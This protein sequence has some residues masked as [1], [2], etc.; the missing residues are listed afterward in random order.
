MVCDIEI[1]KNK[2]IISDCKIVI[3]G[4]GEVG[5]KT[6]NV[7]RMCGINVYAFCKT[8]P[9]RG[10]YLYGKIV[11]SVSEL[12]EQ[13]TDEMLLVMATEIYMDE[14]YREITDR[15][16]NPKYLCTY[17]AVINSCLLNNNCNCTPDKYNEIEQIK[18]IL[19]NFWC[20][21]IK[22]SY[23]KFLM[24]V[25]N[26]D[27]II[28]YTPGKVGTISLSCS[29]INSTLVHHIGLY[30]Y[31][32]NTNEQYKHFDEESK[33]QIIYYL[34]RIKS[35]KLKLISLVR[36]PLSRDISAFFHEYDWITPL[37]DQSTNDLYEDF[38]TVIDIKMKIKKDEFNWFIS[39]MYN[40][41]GVNVYE[42]PFDR[43]LGYT[44]I[45]EKNVELLLIKLEKL[46]ELEKVIGEFVE[47]K[48]F[49]LGVANQASKRKYKF[50]YDEFKQNVILPKKYVDYYYKGNKYMD[51][52]YTEEEKRMFL[53]KWNKNIEK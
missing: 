47:D 17:F 32:F 49:K 30:G 13:D 1:I 44:I 45:K 40:V 37:F 15:N 5:I 46:K 39:E 33:S 31:T 35:K 9:E 23:I 4:T 43:E 22:T 51:H 53:T 28:I 20:S 10:E 16:I 7:L 21:N 11:F 48:N 38:N 50:A 6:Y 52:F 8:N 3:Y 12:A 27:S 34:N 41:I 25:V 14:V 29:L 18:K 42:H 24:S 26:N 2:N 36:E 19:F